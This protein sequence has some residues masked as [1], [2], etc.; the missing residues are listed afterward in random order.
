MANLKYDKILGITVGD[1]KIKYGIL[2]GN[3]K[4]IF[5]KAGAPRDIDEEEET[6]EAYIDKYLIMAHRVHARTG[7]TVICAS[8]SDLS[9]KTQLKADKTLIEKVIADLGLDHYELYFIGN[10]DGGDHSL[11]LSQQFPQTVKFLGINSSYITMDAFVER[12]LSLSHVQ[13]IFV[14]G[15]K[16][17]DFDCIVP[18]LKALECDNLEIVILDGVD[19]EFTG[20]ID[21]F[22]ALSDLI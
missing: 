18:R 8:N 5:I 12:V 19:H 17:I 1:E 2:Y 20:R 6:H 14:Y 7:A 4:I 15:S 11:K 10:S 13:K 22:I 9:G 3:E 16:D 21:D